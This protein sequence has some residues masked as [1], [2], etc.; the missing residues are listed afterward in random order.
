MSFCLLLN[1]LLDSLLSSNRSFSV[2]F[3]TSYSPGEWTRSLGQRRKAANNERCL[4]LHGNCIQTIDDLPKKRGTANTLVL[5]MKCQIFSLI[6]FRAH[7]V[8]SPHLSIGAMNGGKH[9]SEFVNLLQI[10][11]RFVSSSFV[12][13]KLDQ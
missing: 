10:L 6:L 9:G 4:G 12:L 7:D 2:I 3:N 5:R 13:F 8:S 11:I 1:E